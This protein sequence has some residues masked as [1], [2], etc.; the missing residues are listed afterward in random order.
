MNKALITDACNKSVLGYQASDTCAICPCILTMHTAFEKY[1]PFYNKA[2]YSAY[3][4]S[5]LLVVTKVKMILL[6]CF[7]FG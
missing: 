6:R 1:K 4:L 7:P 5:M 2:S 3:P